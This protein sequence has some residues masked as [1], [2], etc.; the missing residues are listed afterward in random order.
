MVVIYT[1]SYNAPEFIEIQFKLFKKYLK[2]DFKYVVY[3]N[4]MT[5][6]KITNKNHYNNVKLKEICTKHDISWHDVPGNIFTR[7]DPSNRAGTSIN[8]AISHVHNTYID[9]LYFLI[10]SDLFPVSDID[11][12]EIMTNSYFSGRIQYR[13][14]VNTDN[15]ISY[16]TN[17]IVIYKKSRINNMLNYLSFN[18]VSINGAICDCG[19]DTHY[20]IKKIDKLKFLNWTNIL[21]SKSGNTKQLYGNSPD[22]LSD[23]NFKILD[24][25]NE[26]LRQFIINDTNILNKLGP[27]C[28]VFSINNNPLFLHLRAGSNWIN[29]DIQKRKDNLNTYIELLLTDTDNIE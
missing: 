25:F 11:I 28:E 7:Q 1:V 9:E 6:A 10:D 23:F 8:Y 3:N 24:T 18:P 15:D 22:M 4:T 17:Q 19:G 16:V 20:I 5:D 12:A 29:Y 13:K 14:G 27:F 2:N 26:P 21:F